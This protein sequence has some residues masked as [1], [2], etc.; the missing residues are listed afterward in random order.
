MIEVMPAA[1]RSSSRIGL[2]TQSDRSDVPRGW[3]LGQVETVA[4][5]VVVGR[6][7][8]AEVVGVTVVDV[9]LQVGPETHD[10]A[11]EFVGAPDE[12]DALG[13]QLPEVDGVAAVAPLTAMVTCS[14]PAGGW[15]RPRAREPEPPAE[16]AVAVAARRTVVRTDGQVDLFAGAVQFVGDLH[17]GRSGADD[18]HRTV[19]QL[20]GLR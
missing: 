18:Q 7:E 9:R 6:V 15:P 17:T 19:G 12:G 10:A 1:A 20:P 16:V 3:L 11:I 4:F 5:D 13:R 8:H 2:L 14:A